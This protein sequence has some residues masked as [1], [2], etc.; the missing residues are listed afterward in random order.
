MRKWLSSSGTCKAFFSL[1][2]ANRGAHQCHRGGLGRVAKGLGLS[3]N[4]AE[5][6]PRQV[7]FSPGNL[8]S[9]S[10]MS[11]VLP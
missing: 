11:Y 2:K 5:F 4:A 6:E 7:H 3:V 10:T 9:Y 8:Q 1:G